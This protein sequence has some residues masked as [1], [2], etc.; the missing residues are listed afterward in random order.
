[1]GVWSSAAGLQPDSALP[2]VEKAVFVLIIYPVAR[3]TG[4]MLLSVL[5]RD[6]FMTDDRTGQQCFGYILNIF[7]KAFK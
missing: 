1:M 2:Q 4:K 7:P 5:R 6:E 3:Q